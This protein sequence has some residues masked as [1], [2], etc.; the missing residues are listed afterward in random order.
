MQ[1]HDKNEKQIPMSS[2]FALSI[3]TATFSSEQIITRAANYTVFFQGHSLHVYIFPSSSPLN[4]SACPSCANRTRRSSRYLG[5]LGSSTALY[6][7]A[8]PASTVA[9]W[10]SR[11]LPLA[12]RVLRSAQ[13]KALMLIEPTRLRDPKV[14]AFLAGVTT[15]SFEDAGSVCVEA[16]VEPNVGGYGNCSGVGVSA[17]ELVYGAGNGQLEGGAPGVAIVSKFCCR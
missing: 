5:S 3:I 10:R 15:C 6:A 1:R 16:V 17:E 13:F 9:S 4:H 7:V 11:C 12:S 8:P 14:C 2:T